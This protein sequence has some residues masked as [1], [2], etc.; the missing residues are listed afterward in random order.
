MGAGVPARTSCEL[1]VEAARLS[2]NGDCL[3]WSSGMALTHLLPFIPVLHRCKTCTASED[4][5]RQ[6]GAPL[7]ARHHVTRP[8]SSL[9]HRMEELLKNS[10][11]NGVNNR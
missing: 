11:E 3:R 4:C 6:P 10:E 1:S 5:Y 2:A 9:C 8:Y 7:R